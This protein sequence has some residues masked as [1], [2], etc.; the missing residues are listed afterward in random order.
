MSYKIGKVEDFKTVNKGKGFT[1]IPT[2]KIDPAFS[3][4]YINLTDGRD[5]GDIDKVTEVNP[6]NNVLYILMKGEIAFTLYGESTETVTL[7]EKEYIY[8][9]PGTKYEITGSGELALVM[10]PAYSDKTFYHPKKT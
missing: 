6:G 1:V 2:G 10:T 9:T 3:I 8:L 7:K 4:T 5:P